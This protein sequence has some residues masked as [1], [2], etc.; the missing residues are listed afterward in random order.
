MDTSDSARPDLPAEI[1]LKLLLMDLIDAGATKRYHTLQAAALATGIDRVLLSRIRHGN[2]RRCSIGTLFNLADV[3]GIR[4][5]IEVQLAE[6][7][8]VAITATK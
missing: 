7:P 3:L 4:L 8:E 1:M 2:H 6:S 5:R